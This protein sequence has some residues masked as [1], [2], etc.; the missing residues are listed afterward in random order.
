MSIPSK[1]PWKDVSSEDFIRWEDADGNLI[2][3]V[4]RPFIQAHEGFLREAD[5]DHALKAVNSVEEFDT[6]D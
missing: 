6:A 2:Y 4:R 1:R 5:E 3:E